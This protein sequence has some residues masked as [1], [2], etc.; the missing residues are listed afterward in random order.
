MSKFFLGS[1]SES[2]NSATNSDT[3]DSD[4]VKVVV[5]NKAKFVND[6]ESDSGKCIDF[7]RISQLTLISNVF[8]RIG[9]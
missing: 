3:D 6:F 2:D 9:R 8:F 5:S 4:E 1:S 7:Y